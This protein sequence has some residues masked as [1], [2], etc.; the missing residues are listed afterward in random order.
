MNVLHKVYSKELPEIQ[1]ETSNTWV[2]KLTDMQATLCSNLAISMMIIINEAI[3]FA[4]TAIIVSFWNWHL[5]LLLILVLVPSIGFF[6][7][8]IKT[9]IKVAG[10]EKNKSFVYLYEKAQE[11]IFGYTDIKIAGTEANFKKSFNET[12]KK[13]S[14]MQGKVDFTLFIP[15][16]I[17]E[18]AIFIC[19]VIILLYGVYII[20]DINTI[21][22]TI[23]LFSVVAYRSIP[24]VN[25]FVIAINSVNATEFVLEDHDF[26][27]DKEPT[28]KETVTPLSFKESVILDKLSYHYPG[29]SKYVVHNFN[30]EIRKGDK[31]GIIGS[32]GTGK[33]TLVNNFLGFL[34]PSLGRILVDGTELNQSNHRNWWKILGYVRQDAF[35][36][37]TTLAENI[38]IGETLE[39]I[40]IE[41]INRAVNLS[42]LASLV[43]EW[44]EG[45]YTRLSERGNN[46]SGGQKQRIAIA[47]AIYKGAEILVFDEATSALDSKTEEEITDAINKLG[48]EHLTIIIIAHRYTSLKFCDKIY[49]LD[50]GRISNTYSYKELVSAEQ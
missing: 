9:M 16:R 24:S 30:L 14:V 50:N 38:A 19:I 33:S 23:T 26:F 37:N 48:S 15:T 4:L 46:L 5:F 2:N 8:R 22:T 32:S 40:D 10:Q 18:I 44:P 47:R 36:L 49:K 27:P 29:S 45:I 13:Y 12:A 1:K 34:T 42:S 11:M 35:I 20:K 25:R 6:Y 21:V 17:I 31:I 41:K 43:A 7:Y 3:V 39:Q 28:E